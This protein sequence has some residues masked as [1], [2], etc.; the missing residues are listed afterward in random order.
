MSH[1]VQYQLFFFGNMIVSYQYLASY[2]EVALQK[3]VYI[4]IQM[5][6]QV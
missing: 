1:V 6:L 2:C 3:L 4:F 5:S